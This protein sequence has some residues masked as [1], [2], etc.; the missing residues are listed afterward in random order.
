MLLFRNKKNT[1]CQGQ[2]KQNVCVYGNP[3]LPNQAWLGKKKKKKT[4][5]QNKSKTLEPF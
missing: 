4:K 5:S 2:T 3:I 1:Y